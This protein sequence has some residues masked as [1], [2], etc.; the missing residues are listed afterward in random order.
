MK[1]YVLALLFV[2]ALCG[3]CIY[4]CEGRKYKKHVRFLSALLLM[5]VLFAP[6]PMILHEKLS[7]PDLLRS[8]AIESGDE[9]Y[10]EALKAESE[11]AKSAD[12]KQAK[13]D[14]LAASAGLEE[15]PVTLE[16]GDGNF[17]ISHLWRDHKDLF[18]D[19]TKA[20]LIL[21]E[22]LG[23]PE[24]RVVVSL[25][26]E[27]YQK[28]GAKIQLCRKRLV[29]HNPKT[30][31]YLVMRLADDER[32]LQVVSFNRAPDSYGTQQWVLE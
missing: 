24:C 14:E 30:R 26:Q 8:S 31:A 17:G 3:G 16:K 23:W 27:E 12:E 28:D 22:T 9:A 32:S 25:K 29:L 13:L 18:L 4:L 10:I 5:T 19:P 20:S 21:Q 1:A 15:L 2:S 6:L 7:L 11:K